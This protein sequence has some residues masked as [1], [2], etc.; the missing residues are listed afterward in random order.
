MDVPGSVL[1]NDPIPGME[2]DLCRPRGLGKLFLKNPLASR[3]TRKC[4]MLI[5]VALDQVVA[6]GRKGIAID[7]I[8]DRLRV[9]GI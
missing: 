1:A 3:C 5:I 8:K 6:E 4:C 2:M 9:R 7:S